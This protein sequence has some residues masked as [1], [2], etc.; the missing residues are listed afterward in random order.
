MPAVTVD[1]GD[2][3][4]WEAA[5]TQAVARIG[6]GEL[7]KVVLARAVEATASA[8]LDTRAILARLAEDYPSCWTFA[9]DGLV[10]ATPEPAGSRGPW[11]RHVACAGGHDS[12][13]GRRDRRPRACR[14]ART[15]VQGPRGT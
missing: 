5:V 8:P 14:R 9:V 7:D 4:A 6:A 3:S 15:L 13:H 1:L 12:P 10:G 2:R 11:S